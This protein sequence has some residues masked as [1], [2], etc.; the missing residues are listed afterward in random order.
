ML[1]A[2]RREAAPRRGRRCGHGVH[3]AGGAAGYGVVVPSDR[4]PQEA[5]VPGPT[6]SQPGWYPDADGNQRWYDGNA[7]T[8]HVRGDQQ[9]A[10]QG[11]A[12][13]A[14]QGAAQGDE[15]VAVPPEPT[16]VLPSLPPPPP[17]PPPGTLGTPSSLEVGGGK[18]LRIAIAVL[19]VVLLLAIVVVGGIVLLGK[20]DGGKDEKVSEETS[21]TTDGDTPSDAPTSGLDLPTIDPS[22]FPTD[23]PSGLPSDLPS[24]PFPT[25]LP[26]EFP[27]DLL[28]SDFPTNPSELESWF[29]DFL[30][31]V[32][33]R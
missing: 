8:D 9:G 19:G 28:P 23:L 26:S 6:P 27:T 30:E 12:Q 4:P 32:S 25:K 2:E 31:Q 24:I 13:G 7:W 33:P 21:G 11:G 22:D 18:G 1:D 14:A 29:S 20:D 17:G 10:A 5:R 15:T 3:C 16:A